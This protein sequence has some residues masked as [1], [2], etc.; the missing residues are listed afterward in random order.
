MPNCAAFAELLVGGAL[1]GATAVPINTRF[2]ARELRHVVSDGRLAAIYTTDAVDEFTNFRA[3][4]AESVP[5]LA[6]AGDP[7]R[8]DLPDLPELRAV[9]LVGDRETLRHL[10][11]SAPEPADAAG[12]DDA[13]LIMYTSGTTA[14]P[15]GC[16]LTHRAMVLNSRAVADRLRIPPEDRWWDP[17]PFFHMGGTMLMSALFSVGAAFVTSAYFDPDASIDLILRERI[18]VH[19]PLFPTIRLLACAA[20]RQRRAARRP[21]PDPGRVRAGCADQRVRDHRALRDRVLQ[22]PG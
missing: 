20:R 16:V 6:D 10:A 15:K 1:A 12:P 2:K 18:T 14:N 21:A 11:E 7:L 5:G 8:L 22:R 9:A 13:A 3:L 4:L 19:Y 17:L